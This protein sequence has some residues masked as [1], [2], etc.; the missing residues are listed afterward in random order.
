MCLPRIVATAIVLALSSTAVNANLVTNGSFEQPGTGCASGTTS[1]P[2]W[3]VGGNIDIDNSTAPC[4]TIPAADGSYFVDLTGS[5]S[6]GSITQ[7]FATTVGETYS[8]SF[9][10]G[11]NPQWQYLSYPN[12]SAIKSMNVGIDGNVVGTYS[13]DTTGLGF[14]DAG[15]TQRSFLFT[16]TSDSTLLGFTSLNS[17]GVYGPLLDNVNVESVPEPGTLVLFGLGLAGLGVTRRRSAS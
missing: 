3:T 10:F 15:W 1:L 12:D 8:V 5:F 16:A 6:A 14:S 2:G 9:F 11:G 7:A 13:I 17:V 4:S